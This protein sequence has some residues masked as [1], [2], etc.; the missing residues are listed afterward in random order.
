[1]HRRRLW[2]GRVA[3]CQRWRE[4][5]KGVPG[6]ERFQVV[7]RQLD[8]LDV[9]IVREPRF[10]E[11]A[12]AMI[13]HET[14]RVLGVQI[15]LHSHFVDDIPLAPV[16]SSASR[17]RTYSRAPCPFSFWPVGCLLR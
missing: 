12:L 17:C 2:R 10:D 11:Q 16:A 3:P 4:L 15:E 14:R 7:Q 5:G 6:V 8:R 13:E 9:S 1:M